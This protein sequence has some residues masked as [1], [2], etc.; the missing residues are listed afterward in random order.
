[1]KAAFFTRLAKGCDLPA[2]AR[3]CR[4]IAASAWL[5][6]ASSSSMTL[7]G[8][9]VPEAVPAPRATAPADAKNPQGAAPDF[10][11]AAA[12]RAPGTPGGAPIEA[13]FYIDAIGDSLGVLAGEGLTQA[14]ANNSQIAVVTRARGSSGLVR[15]DYYDWIKAAHD[16]AAGKDRIDFEIGRA[17][18]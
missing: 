10:L 13:Q 15:D 5:A 6:W 12:A 11:P 8:D 3:R 2:L 7:A 1:M 16:L 4:M 18:V 17:H 14:Y 9:V